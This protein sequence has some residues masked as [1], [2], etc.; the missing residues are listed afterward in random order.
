MIRVVS[1]E[2]AVPV[3]SRALWEKL[4]SALPDARENE[5]GAMAE[6]AVCFSASAPPDGGEQTRGAVRGRV[7]GPL[8]HLERPSEH[9]GERRED[10]AGKREPTGSRRSCANDARLR[11][12]LVLDYNL[13]LQD[14]AFLFLVQELAQC[15]SKSD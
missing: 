3:V 10:R 8:T 7:D 1:C 6:G 12:R 5:W 14:V 9:L 13:K 11:R 2:I 4:L 15:R